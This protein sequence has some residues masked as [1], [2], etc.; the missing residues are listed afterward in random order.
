MWKDM[1]TLRIWPKKRSSQKVS[2]STCDGKHDRDLMEEVTCLTHGVDHDRDTARS[3]VQENPKILK[4]HYD[5]GLIFI[6]TRDLVT[7]E[8]AKC[9]KSYMLNMWLWTQL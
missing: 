6:T 2:Q 5:K 1:F 8:I 7:I 9:I 4:R 3:E